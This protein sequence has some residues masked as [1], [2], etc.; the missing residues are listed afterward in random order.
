MQLQSPHQTS[1]SLSDF[2]V[3][4][5][6][7]VELE[8]ILVTTREDKLQQVGFLLSC[9]VCLFKDCVDR[10]YDSLSTVSLKGTKWMCD[11]SL[12]HHLVFMVKEDTR[13]C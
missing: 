1:V 10:G 11:E 13:E 12:F 5:I 4:M 6:S 2:C 7:D 3:D 9:C 8:S